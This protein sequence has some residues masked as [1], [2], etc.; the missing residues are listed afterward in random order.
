MSSNDLQSQIAHLHT[1]T[2][3]HMVGFCSIVSCGTDAGSRCGR[4]SA[5]THAHHLL[6]SQI[7]AILHRR[8]SSDSVN[9]E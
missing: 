3:T 2:R 8:I 7:I 1:R 6:G 4:R 9:G 5:A